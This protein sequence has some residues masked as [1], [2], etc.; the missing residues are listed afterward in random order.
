M[1]MF[2]SHWFEEIKILKTCVSSA[3]KNK[4]SEIRLYQI[5]IKRPEKGRK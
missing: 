4:Q 5:R 3:Q 1:S 2:M